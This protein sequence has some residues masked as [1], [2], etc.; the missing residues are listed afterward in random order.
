MM[1][2]T[3]SN[4]PDPYLL[5]FYTYLFAFLCFQLVLSILSGFIALRRGM[6]TPVLWALIVLLFPC[7]GFYVFLG[8]IPRA[9]LILCPH[10]EKRR[11]H[12]LPRCPHCGYEIRPQ[13]SE[14]PK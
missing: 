3:A 6:D 4:V 10:C 8:G 12:H 9:P 1:I 2:E 11:P 7:L 13:S 14:M 5:Y